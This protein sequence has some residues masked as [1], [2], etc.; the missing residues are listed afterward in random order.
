MNKIF[1]GMTSNLSKKLSLTIITV[2][3]IVLNKKLTLNLPDEVINQ[4]A[5]LVMVYLV[6]QSG[7]DIVK[8]LGNNNN[9]TNSSSASDVEVK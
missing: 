3:I 2:A 9:T 1:E 7:V 5:S 8:T 6:G 4:L